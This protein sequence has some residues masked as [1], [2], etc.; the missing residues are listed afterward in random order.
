MGVIGLDTSG[1][2]KVNGDVWIVA[3]RNDR[4]KYTGVYI[5]AEFQTHFRGTKNWVEKLYGVLF[6]KTSNSL[7]ESGDSIMI[8]KDFQGSHARYI[9]S[10]ILTGILLKSISSR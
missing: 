3:I 10:L 8:D 7:M 4:K 6:Y 9:Y 2:I 1:Q 5:N